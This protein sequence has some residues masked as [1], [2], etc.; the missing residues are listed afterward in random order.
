VGGEVRVGHG[1]GCDRAGDRC[2]GVG[3]DRQVGCRGEAGRQVGC[4]GEAG[5]QVG[6]CGEAGRQVGCRGE[7]GRQVGCC[8]GSALGGLLLNRFVFWWA[9]RVSK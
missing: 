6:C 7:A 9:V 8:G 4:C 2:G 3:C 5:R 1:A